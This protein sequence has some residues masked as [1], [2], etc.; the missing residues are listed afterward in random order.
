[1]TFNPTWTTPLDF[2]QVDHSSAAAKH[3]REVFER[4][5]TAG[6]HP[7]AQLVV[8]QHGRILFDA[9][10]GIADRQRNVPVTPD[11][12]F[13]LYSVTK[14]FTA[15]CVHQLVEQGK[16][17]LDAPIATY[18][19]EFGCKG[20]EIATVR[21]ALLHQAGIPR[22]GLNRQVFLWWN[23]ELLAR[24][25]ANLP[26]EFPPGTQTAYHTV[27]YGFILGEVVRRVTGESIETRLR[28]EFLRP[29]G[30]R[31]SFAGLPAGEHRRA[32]RVYCADPVQRSAAFL[33]NLRPVRRLFIP[34]ASLNTTARDLAVF[35][36]MLLNG[37]QYAGRRYLEPETIANAVAL[38]YEGAD[39]TLGL[40]VRWGLGFSLGGIANLPGED[41]LIMGRRSSARTFGH[42]GQGGCGFGWA[43]PD[44]GV[45]FAFANNCL[46]EQ[47]TAHL[48]FQALADAVWE[49][50]G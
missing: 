15:V 6:L 4:Q 37:G 48:R 5:L 14:A 50:V 9:A 44:S 47:R 35:Y 49:G 1:M 29:L 27:N 28:R 24:S 7:G 22:R 19:P 36:Q 38:R 34:A 20:K 25:I 10:A 33:F 3:I 13:L 40:P 30:M 43:D 2:A 16:I 8:T 26:A 45:V 42:P 41:I 17:E 12:P 23:R 46:Q 32:A 21:H 31:N 39:S 11:T 18:W